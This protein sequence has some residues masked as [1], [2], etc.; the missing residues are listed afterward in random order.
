M[1]CEIHSG[2]AKC[3]LRSQ[4]PLKSMRLWITGHVFVLQKCS[5]FTQKM[6]EKKKNCVKINLGSDFQGEGGENVGIWMEGYYISSEFRE[7]QERSTLA[8]VVAI[9]VDE[10]TNMYRVYLDDRYSPDDL[11]A[12]KV[13]DKITLRARPYVSKDGKLAWADGEIG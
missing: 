11:A 1:T 13:G 3:N 5:I 9:V 2:D 8:V 12:Y 6:L 4:A 10:R 7:Y